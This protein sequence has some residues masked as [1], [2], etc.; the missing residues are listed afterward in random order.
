[1]RDNEKKGTK[2][3]F[4]LLF[5]MIGSALYIWL[6]MPMLEKEEVVEEKSYEYYVDKEIGAGKES[7]YVYYY[8]VY[9][10]LA[11]RDNQIFWQCKIGRTEKN[12]LER[13]TN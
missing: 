6:I 12:V 9:R 5:I 8:D 2:G 1:M 11:Q 10:E 4:V 3:L 13:V 7:V